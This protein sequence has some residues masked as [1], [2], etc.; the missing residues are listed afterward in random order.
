[1]DHLDRAGA[2]LPV[3]NYVGFASLFA[4]LSQSG[5]LAAIEDRIYA[6]E[7]GTQ[8]GVQHAVLRGHDGIA[9]RSHVNQGHARLQETLV[10]CLV[11]WE[12]LKLV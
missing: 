12:M 9:L 3:T 6:L 7:L 10:S 8:F 11:G 4:L 5:Q 2:L 1:M